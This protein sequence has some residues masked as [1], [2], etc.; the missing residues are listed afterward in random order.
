M[1]YR[2]DR[3]LWDKIRSL[4]PLPSWSMSSVSLS[5]SSSS[6][7]R[8]PRVRISSEGPIAEASS[9]P[10]REQKWLYTKHQANKQVSPCPYNFYLHINAAVNTCS[11]G[12]E[13]CFWIPKIQDRLHQHHTQPHIK[14]RV[15]PL[16]ELFPIPNWQ[17]QLFW[18]IS[19]VL[20][21]LYLY[22]S[23]S[24]SHVCDWHTAEPSLTHPTGTKAPLLFNK[25]M[26]LS[27]FCC[28]DRKALY[29]FSR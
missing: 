6:S 29:D 14:A 23:A 18:S 5:L 26:L 15:Q 11:K 21:H 7:S 3:Q 24:S 9:G 4:I 2:L 19:L 10:W 8:V 13:S 12:T 20:V 25:V 27:C 1:K 22:S 16:A 17:F 28:E